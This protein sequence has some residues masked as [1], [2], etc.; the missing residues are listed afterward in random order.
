MN[1]VLQPIIGN[2]VWMGSDLAKTSDWKIELSAQNIKE[3]ES[4]LLICKKKQILAHQI[5]PKDFPL[6]LLSVQLKVLEKEVKNGRGF[7]VIRRIPIQKFTEDEA[8]IISWGICSHFGTAIPQSH[9]GDW[10]NHV[11]DLTDVK[12]TTDPDFIH[13]VKRKELRTNHVGGELEF[14]TDTTDIIGLFCLNQAKAGGQSRLASSA[15]VHNM[16]LENDPRI[17]RALY[18]GY[19]YMSHSEDNEQA[20]PRV[21]SKR[22]PVFQRKGK[23]I[24]CYYIPQV[25]Q[26]A[27]DQGKVKYNSLENEARE[28]IQTMANAPGVPFEMTFK[29]GDL[30]LVNNRILLHAR[31]DYEDFPEIDRRRHLFR[32]WMA[33][34]PEMSSKTFKAP[35]DRFSY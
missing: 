12:T 26:R 30:Q 17:L 8:K 20:N 33:T 3:L 9:Q 16:L 6:P 13:V 18:E 32:L 1:E 28:Q 21:T 31:A 14:H 7:A 35:S 34:T 15:M 4:A 29:A 5:K 2:E 25:I 27:I 10:T 11:I 19:Y 23:Q 24:T 22:V